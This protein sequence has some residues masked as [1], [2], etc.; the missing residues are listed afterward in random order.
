MMEESGVSILVVDMNILV[1]CY[2]LKNSEREKARY[3][4]LL[5]AKETE[6]PVACSTK[7]SPV[8]RGHFLAGRLN[9]NPHCSSY[10]SFYSPSLFR[11][12]W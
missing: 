5:N 2:R 9:S 4:W 10:F 12:P 1:V 11:F 8:Q 6:T 3:A 7:L